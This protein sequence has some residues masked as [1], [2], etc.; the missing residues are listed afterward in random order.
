MPLQPARAGSSGNTRLAGSRLFLAVA[1]LAL[2]GVA[3]GVTEFAMM[4]LLQEAAWDL[5]ITIPQAG[6]LITAYALGVV[7]GAPVIT[8]AAARVARR[9]LVLW[10][11]AGL[12]VAN[13]LCWFADGY[14]LMLLGRF[15]SG[16]PHGAYFGVAALVAAN[17]AGPEMRGRAVA[18]VM[19][20]LSVAN[21]VGVPAVTFLGQQ[22]G[23]RVMFLFVVV[24]A[25]LTL[26]CVL[27]F[28]PPRAK[29]ADASI[30]RELGGFRSAGL[31]LAMLTGIVG[32]GGF[33]AVYSYISPIMTEVTGLP[34]RALPWVLALYGAGMVAGNLVGGRLSDWSVPKTIYLV[35]LFIAT[36]KVVFYFVSPVPM[37][38]IVMVFVLGTGGSML[39]PSLQ[40]LL[41]DAAPRAQSLAASLNHSALNVANALGAWLGGMVIALGWGYRAPALL[42]G[43]LA[44]L[45]LIV[46]VFAVYAITVPARI[47]RS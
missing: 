16:V 18:W 43:G 21:L 28:V 14:G 11:A 20:G 10:L 12:L 34:L 17:L 1:S 33:F 5:D 9:T 31:W 2:G 40:T 7:V 35:L 27:V 22:F 45:G 42:G 4:G 25:A 15:F 41:M 19:L 36:A 32:F 30:R 46:A 29:D 23:W 44:L 39:I 38:A 37:L 24:L 3:I 26:L 6:H 47:R 8:I 13:L